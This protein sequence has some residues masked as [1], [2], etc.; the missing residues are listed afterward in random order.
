MLLVERA[1]DHYYHLSLGNTSVFLIRWRT[2]AGP[3]TTTS[4]LMRRESR[5]R[6]R[7]IW[8]ITFKLSTPLSSGLQRPSAKKVDLS[9]WAKWR[10]QNPLRG[11]SRPT[12]LKQVETFVA[13][14]G[15]EDKTDLFKKGALLA[16]NP[17]DFENLDVLT[18]DDKVMIRRE[19]TRQFSSSSSADLTNDESSL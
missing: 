15:L 16:Q 13:E 6:S 3:A 17:K 10:I 12:L 14:K 4:A 2:K 1:W 8:P 5:F 9:N 18:E 11:I 19:T 7:S